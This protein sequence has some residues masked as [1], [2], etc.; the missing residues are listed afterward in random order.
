VAIDYDEVIFYHAGKF[1]SRD[2]MAPGM[3]T[4]ASLRVHARPPSKRAEEHAR[5]VKFH[6]GRVRRDDRPLLSLFR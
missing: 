1:F 3:M 4:A 5:P 6:D 2:D